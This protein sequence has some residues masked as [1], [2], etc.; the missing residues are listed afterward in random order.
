MTITIGDELSLVAGQPAWNIKN[1]KIAIPRMM[2]GMVESVGEGLAAVRADGE[3]YFIDL[4]QVPADEH[5]TKTRPA[6]PPTPSGGM[7]N[8]TMAAVR[9]GEL[10][11][12]RS[13]DEGIVARFARGLRMGFV[14]ISVAYTIMSILALTWAS[15]YG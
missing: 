2:V 9:F 7:P 15:C 6:P 11:R 1:K 8:D 3:L 5:E 10:R 4:G 13:H 14:L 12:K